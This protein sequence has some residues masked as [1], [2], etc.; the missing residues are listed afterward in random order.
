MKSKLT[1]EDEVEIFINSS[2]KLNGVTLE[3]VFDVER[4][5]S[6]F[7][8]LHSVI[9]SSIDESSIPLVTVSFL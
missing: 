6:L 8:G 1:F 7:G 5:N 9:S 2:T 3:Y 4:G